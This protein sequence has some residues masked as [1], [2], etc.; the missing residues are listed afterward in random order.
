MVIFMEKAYIKAFYTDLAAYNAGILAGD[1]IDLDNDLTDSISDVKKREFIDLHD[2]I[3]RLDHE[4]FITDYDSNLHIDSGDEYADLDQLVELVNVIN[5]QN[6]DPE[7]ANVILDN[8]CDLSHAIEIIQNGDFT[9]WNTDSDSDYDLGSA[10][11]DETGL[12]DY[13]PANIAQYFDFEAYGRDYRLST[14]GDF[15]ESGS[16]Y[17]AIY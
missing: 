14:I 3:N 10:I 8:E 13:T 4:F 2:G 5:D 6:L 9:V 16:Y 15:S 17:V 7:I 11:A 12:L 1:W